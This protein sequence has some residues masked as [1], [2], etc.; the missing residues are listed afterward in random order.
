MAIDLVERADAVAGVAL[1]ESA[2]AVASAAHGG[3]VSRVA[4]DVLLEGGEVTSVMPP[5]HL[6]TALAAA[7]GAVAHAKY[8]QSTGWRAFLSESDRASIA[9]AATA[10]GERDFDGF[11]ERV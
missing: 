1:H 2:H 10:L 5:H 9:Q 3:F 6:D 7:A 8:H 11:L 4:L